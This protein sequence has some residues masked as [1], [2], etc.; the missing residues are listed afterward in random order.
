[1]N[2]LSSVSQTQPQT[3]YE[4]VYEWCHVIGAVVLHRTTEFLLTEPLTSETAMV[5][6]EEALKDYPQCQIILLLYMCMY[7]ILFT[8][9]Q[10]S[11]SSGAS[12]RS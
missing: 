2:D 12:R 11:K 9:L 7:G 8:N 3:E 6:V 10:V 4:R 1:M 5:D